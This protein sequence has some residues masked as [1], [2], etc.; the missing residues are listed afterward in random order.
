MTLEIKPR[1][2]SSELFTKDT[3]QITHADSSLVLSSQLKQ[4]IDSVWSKFL[5]DAKQ[6]GGNPWDGTY[7]RLENIDQVQSGE[8][9]LLFSTIKFSQ[10]KGLTQDVDLLATLPED[11][12]PSHISTT[13]LIHTADG[14]FV[15]GERNKK[16]MSSSSFD[17]IGG[18]LQPDEI[19]VNSCQNI[20]TSQYKE[21]SEEASIEPKDVAKIVGIGITHSSKY[22]VI[23]MFY[24]QLNVT[25]AQVAENFATSTDDEM[26][27]LLFI[28]EAELSE[29]L[30]DKGSY[31]PLA[32]ELYA[33]HKQFL[34]NNS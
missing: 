23:F 17:F 31:R 3:Y 14:Y 22:N 30:K 25:R 21:M 16:T 20:F 19:V 34:A 4:Q 5:T 29:F 28:Q 24:A 13:A 1:I 7:Y 27:G 8:S 18:G 11:S 2:L 32:A 6:K 15:F 26:S 10:I 9:E 33:T 12:R